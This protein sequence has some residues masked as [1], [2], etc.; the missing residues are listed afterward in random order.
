MSGPSGLLSSVFR[1]VYR[2]LL[3]V[4]PKEFRWRYGDE[5]AQVFGDRCR[6]ERRRGGSIALMRLMPRTLMDLAA[7]ALE[8]HVRATGRGISELLKQAVCEEPR[9]NRSK[10]ISLVIGC[11]N[12]V[13]SAVAILLGDVS[14]AAQ[15]IGLTVGIMFVLL[16]AGDFLYA[17]HRRLA[18]VSRSVSF[19]AGIALLA[20]LVTLAYL[21]EGLRGI[22]FPWAMFAGIAA[23][24]WLLFG[25]NRFSRRVES[26]LAWIGGEDQPRR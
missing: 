9:N 22:V 8:E 3:V 2:A 1:R 7:T 12:L 10:W 13:V 6:E 14:F 23:S 21:Q 18:V 5:M 25:N 4:Y 20:I 17:R 11:F 16:G 19:A 26:T 15:W 24:F